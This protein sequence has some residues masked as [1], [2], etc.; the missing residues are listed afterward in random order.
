[1]P[2]SAHATCLT[3]IISRKSK[4]LRINSGHVSGGQDVCTLS[5]KMPNFTSRQHAII[6]CDIVK[7]GPSNRHASPKSGSWLWTL[8][9]FKYVM[10]SRLLK[11][12]P[13]PLFLSCLL[14]K[15]SLMHCKDTL[16][17][18]DQLHFREIHLFRHVSLMFCEGIR[19]TPAVFLSHFFGT[20][21]TLS[22]LHCSYMYFWKM[23]EKYD[24]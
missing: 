16:V 17:D 6:L 22:S 19:R 4:A 24:W 5:P 14:A 1:M 15:D 11:T 9:R 21:R 7:T 20:Q 2:Y 23:G 13:H 12:V 10:C 18:D 3:L 8:K